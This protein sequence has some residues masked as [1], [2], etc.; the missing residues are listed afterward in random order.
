MSLLVYSSQK[1]LAQTK[2]RVL[3]L[4]KASSNHCTVTK[5]QL[6]TAVV[7]ADSWLCKFGLYGFLS[8]VSGI[9][10]D[11]WRSRIC[12]GFK[13]PT[14]IWSN[15]ITLDL[16]FMNAACPGGGFRILPGTIQFQN[17]VPL[18]SPFMV[19]CAKGDV[20][21]ISQHLVDR[22]GYVGDRASC[23]GKTPLLVRKLSSRRTTIWS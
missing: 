7:N 1:R 18:N 11:E 10:N 21:L 3:P 12:V 23:C 5:V 15:S 17:Q 2:P 19:A 9:D 16:Q 13:P 20:R 4:H 8:V 6:R 14:W 22:T